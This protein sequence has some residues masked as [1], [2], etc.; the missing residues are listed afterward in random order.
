MVSGGIFYSYLIHTLLQQTNFLMTAGWMFIVQIA[1]LVFA[2][3]F[4]RS[5]DYLPERGNLHETSNYVGVRIREPS[6]L[7]MVFFIAGCFLTTWGVFIPWNYLP[8][9]AS[10]NGLEGF[11]HYT[12]VV[13]NGGSL[14]GRIA[15]GWA[16]SMIG[17][18]NAFSIVTFICG[19]LVLTVWL[20]LEYYTSSIGILAF[21]F[22]YGLFSGGCVNLGPPSLVALHTVYRLDIFSIAIALGALTGLPIAGAIKDK[23]GGKLAGLICFAGASML[24]AAICMVIARVFLVGRQLSKKI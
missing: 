8:E 23:Q 14:I 18:L 5:P 24:L 9:M 2:N 20:L 11:A 19:T 15:V 1:F 13:A 6:I 3:I 10:L 17:S 12:L 7:G 22:L 16:S 4:Y 21:A